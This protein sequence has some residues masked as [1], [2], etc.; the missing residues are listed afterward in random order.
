MCLISHNSSSH[1]GS[2]TYCLCD[3][4]NAGDGNGQDIL[5][6][7]VLRNVGVSVVTASVVNV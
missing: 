6:N 2:R 1:N 7:V 5:V 3:V 4:F